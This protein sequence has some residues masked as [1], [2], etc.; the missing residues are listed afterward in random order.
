MK[1]DPVRFL[2]LFSNNPFYAYN[3]AFH[4]IKSDTKQAAVFRCIGQLYRKHVIAVDNHIFGIRVVGA[5]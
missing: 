4:P 2:S 3:P 5:I 1:R